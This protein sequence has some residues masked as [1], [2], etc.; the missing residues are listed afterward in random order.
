MITQ[1][2][3]ARIQWA[4]TLRCRTGRHSWLN[5]VDRAH[6]CDPN[7]MFVW[8]TSRNTLVRLGAVNITYR[9]LWS[10]WVQQSMWRG[11]R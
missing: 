7:W 9:G 2:S 4:A 1:R 6:C 10:G 5:A 11:E 8:A 3:V